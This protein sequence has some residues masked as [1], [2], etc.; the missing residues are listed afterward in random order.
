MVGDFISLP[1]STAT[2]SM[3][4]CHVQVIEEYSLS[5]KIINDKPSNLVRPAVLGLPP[6]TEEETPHSF[7]AHLPNQL[8]V[9]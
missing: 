1:I 8:G 5:P 2:N 4:I 6:V 3:P 9:F 7:A